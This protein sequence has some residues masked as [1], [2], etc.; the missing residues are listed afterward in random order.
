MK[1][2]KSLFFS[3]LIFTSISSQA[4]VYN[5]GKL[6]SGTYAP[7]S[8]LATL[9]VTGSGNVYNFTLTAKDL[10]SLFTNGAYIGRLIVD[11]NP[12]I[13]L[14]GPG[15]ATVAI[16]NL[17]GGVTSLTPTNA[18]GP[19][20]S[21]V[22]DFSFSLPNAANNRLTANESLSWTATFSQ[23]VSFTNFGLHVQSLTSAQGGSAWYTPSVT[24]VPE[25]ESLG[26][27]AVGLC[28]IG[29]VINRRSRKK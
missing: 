7:T 20:G 26:M 21:N 8:T 28:L 16:S 14:V 6:L 29:G 11:T 9:D 2:L 17:V 5:F 19:L 18:G 12:S 23:N 1:Y 15:H 24:P 10:N 25:P 22:W 13:S 4:T 27:V 3:A